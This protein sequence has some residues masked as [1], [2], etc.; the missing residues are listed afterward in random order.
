MTATLAIRREGLEIELR[1][2]TFHVILDDLEVGSN[3]WQYVARWPNEAGQLTLQVKFGRYAS[4]RRTFRAV[5][6]A[7]MNSHC[8][9]ARIWPLYVVSI[10]KADVAI[11]L[12]PE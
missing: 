1:R 2:G 6:G 12:R 9:G 5:D 7:R 10:V 11:S 3:E 8:H 4:Q